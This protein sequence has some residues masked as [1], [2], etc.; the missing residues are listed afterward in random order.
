MEFIMQ[1][2]S[3]QELNAAKIGAIQSAWI[4]E[5]E[6]NSDSLI[7]LSSSLF[8]II[9]S[10][11]NYG[12]LTKRHNKDTY[13]AVV[14][15]DTGEADAIVH[16]VFSKLGSSS[17]CKIMDIYHAPHVSNLEDDMYNKKYYEIFLSVLA[18]MLQINKTTK[19]GVTKIYARDDISQQTIQAIDSDSNKRLI[20]K[21]GFEMKLLGRQWLEFKTI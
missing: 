12:V 14:N 16:I 8:D 21:I 13:M 17:M 7:Q 5:L 11:K 3:L 15:D 18:N 1:S 19:Y 20:E 6:K 2:Y 4:E 9:I 10:Q